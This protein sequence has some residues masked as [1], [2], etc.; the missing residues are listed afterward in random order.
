MPA[1]VVVHKT[2]KYNP[3][4]R[5]G[6]RRA[7][8]EERIEICELLSVSKSLIRLFRNAEYPPLRGTLLSLD[9]CCQALYARGSVDFYA[10]YPGLYMPRTLLIRTDIV[11]KTPTY[12]AQEILA[13]TKMNWNDTQFD[14]GEPITIRAA[15]QVGDIL[16]YVPNDAAQIASNYSYYM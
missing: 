2:S 5:S 1:R 8:N 4:E 7:A 10:T 15:R 11:D 12:H 13:L 3:Q 9:D 6:F 16:K 14:G